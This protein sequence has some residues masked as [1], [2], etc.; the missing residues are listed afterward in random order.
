MSI[1]ALLPSG[2]VLQSL[3][4]PH[5]RQ[6]AVED[7]LLIAAPLSIWSGWCV[8]KEEAGV[9]CLVDFTQCINLKLGWLPSAFL[10]LDKTG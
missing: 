5:N 1:F 6:W 9:H 3:V 10:S 2:L 4:T 8:S 7:H